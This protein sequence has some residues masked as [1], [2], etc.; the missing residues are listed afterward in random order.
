LSRALGPTGGPLRQA[1]LPFTILGL[2]WI[3]AAA[4]GALWIGGRTASLMTGNGWT[5]PKLG[6]DFGR[7]V[8]TGGGLHT[9]WPRTSP[10]LVWTCTAALV[11]AVLGLAGVAA[12]TWVRR[13]AR[14]GDPLPSLATHRELQGL[15]GP[16][17]VRRARRLRPSLGDRAERDIPAADVGVPLGQLRGRSS[18]R[19]ALRASWEDVLLAVMAP[20]A[21]K[22][23]ALAVPAILD[24]PGAVIATSNK[25]DLWMATAEPRAAATGERL[26]VFDPQRIVYADR[27]WWWNPLR[28]VTTVEE[29]HRL[30]GHFVQEVR[31][32]RGDRDF[33]TAAAHDL[34]TGLLLAA[35]SSGRDLVEVYEWLNDPVL[36]TPV[37]LLRAAGHSAAASS[38]LGRM[39]GAPET[40]DGVY[41]TAR[42]AAQ[43]LRDDQIMAWVTPP[44]SPPEQLEELDVAGFATSRQTLYLLSKDGAGA[45]APLVAALTDRI[46]RAA[47]RTAEAAGGRIDPPLLVVLDEAANI[48]RIGDLPELY[49]HFGSRGITPITILQSYKQGVRV[50]GEHGMDALWSA[51]T[52][53]L[54]GPG[55]DD[56][57]LAEDISRLV[58]DHDVPVRSLNHGDRHTG[59]SISLRRQRIL[60]PEDVRAL[61][62]G[63]ALLLA[64][65]CK[66]ALIDLAPWYAGPRAATVRAA[67]ETAQRQLTARASQTMIGGSR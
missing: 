42:T 1:A 5:G 67:A 11:V 20:R 45:A 10:A 26:W 40:R 27:T 51:A 13:Q 56:A 60:P 28:D 46:L 54:I 24:A 12:I 17:A 25:A 6:W 4:L 44:A 22:T 31:P 47:T 53:K 29:A 52:V 43:C 8:V 39:H 14:H 55:L 63:T 34:L 49:S 33:W 19:A 2:C 16:P 58:G 57:R 9:L 64:T 36:A 37:E 66:A 32:E 30:A 23:T 7:T 59:E 48:C 21:G 61:P 50:W 65:G 38:L 3:P 18:D 15:A 41:E 35:A 62:R